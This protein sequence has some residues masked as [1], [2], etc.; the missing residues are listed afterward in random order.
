MSERWL[1]VAG[2]EGR[3]EISDH[4][5][6]K[7]L[8]RKVYRPTG[9]H[10]PSWT[11]YP[12]RILKARIHA[13][14]YPVVCLMKDGKQFDALVHRLVAIAFIDGSGP[15]VR[16]LDGNPANPHFLNLAWGSHGDNEADKER[17][18]RTHQGEKHHNA[19][20]NAD[21]VSLIRAST[22]SDLILSRELGVAR[23]AIYSVRHRL[24][25]DQVP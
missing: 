23:Y 22:K 1:S 7:S 4:G 20:L 14:G 15:L 24:T 21:L 17:H 6:V 18:G 9:R 8:A 5:R 11:H 2:Y 25:W 10:G 19:K 13:A 3:Y 12:E 16:H